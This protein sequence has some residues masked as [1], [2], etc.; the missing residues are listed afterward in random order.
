MTLFTDPGA[1][2]VRVDYLT[3]MGVAVTQRAS[4]EPLEWACGCSRMHDR[5]VFD[6]SFT[7][8]ARHQGALG[9]VPEPN[10]EEDL[11]ELPDEGDLEA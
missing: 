9:E 4:K 8:C 7:V 3:A 1:V 2:R 5:V 6:N 10:P 11:D